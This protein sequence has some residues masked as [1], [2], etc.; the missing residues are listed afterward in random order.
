MH[1]NRIQDNFELFEGRRDK[2]NTLPVPTCVKEELE[3][4][5]NEI[6]R[7]E[8]AFSLKWK[9]IIPEIKKIFPREFSLLNTI[10]GLG[11]KAI[12]V[13]LL[14]IWDISRFPNVKKF[15]SYFGAVATVKSSN[16]KAIGQK[17]KKQKPQYLLDAIRR[18]LNNILKYNPKFRERYRREK[19]SIKN[20][21]KA[22]NNMIA[23]LFEVIYNLLSKGRLHSDFEPV[24]DS[25]PMSE[26][27][28]NDSCLLS[29]E[30][31]SND[32]LANLTQSDLL[33]YELYSRQGQANCWYD[34]TGFYNTSISYIPDE[35]VV[36]SSGAYNLGD[37]TS[38]NN[39]AG[40]TKAEN[41]SS[42][43]S[44]IN[45]AR[46]EERH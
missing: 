7:N 8:Q 38:S 35:F 29:A 16:R 44:A 14:E 40:F 46:A 1:R 28:E 27:P 5:Y 18:Q 22:R 23:L 31:G 20:A 34:E 19:A 9:K 39:F 41:N 30:D 24:S 33:A 15:K 11:D 32:G 4:L 43:S 6:I 10:R 26:V 42:T 37:K 25:H 36:T 3:E 17:S 45:N 21:K 2:I 12:S 13:I